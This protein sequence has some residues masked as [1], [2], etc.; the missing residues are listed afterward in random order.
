LLESASGQRDNLSL[1]RTLR[2]VRADIPILF[3]RHFRNESPESA[4]PASSH[5][6]VERTA[7]GEYLLHCALRN[8]E[9]DAE[10]N[11]SIC[12]SHLDGPWTFE[13]SAPCKVNR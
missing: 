2:A 8:A 7:D 3:V 6:L 10:A 12:G 1:A 13:F 5:C 9:W 11:T 4:K